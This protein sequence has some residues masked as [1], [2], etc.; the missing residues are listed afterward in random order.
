MAM[1]YRKS[2]VVCSFALMSICFI[3][4]FPTLSSAADKH[5][6]VGY[7][8]DTNATVDVVV[9]TKDNKPVAYAIVQL[10]SPG[11]FETTYRTDDE[12]YFTAMIP[13]RTSDNKPITHEVTVTHDKYKTANGTFNTGEKDCEAT[14]K[15][16]F[17]L[18]P[19]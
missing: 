13:C 3:V 14:P 17:T 18:E 4:G 8:V 7:G 9:V 11:A 19:K 6:Q 5:T 12:G 15:V 16:T 2:I 10:K 1:T